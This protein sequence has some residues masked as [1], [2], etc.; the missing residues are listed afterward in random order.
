M[1]HL[2]RSTIVTM[3]LFSTGL[4]A[5]AGDPENHMSGVEGLYAGTFWCEFGEMGMTLTIK[6]EG[7]SAD[8]DMAEANFHNVSGILNFYPTLVNPSMPSG[9]FKISGWVH[10]KGKFV[11]EYE[12]KPGDWI[13]Q[14]KDFGASPMAGRIING[15]VYGKPTVEGCHKLELFKMAE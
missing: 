11:Q 12:F 6:D 14:P 1:K 8:T 9:A 2:I 3:A 5:S 15:K 7:L 4:S 13:D 10:A